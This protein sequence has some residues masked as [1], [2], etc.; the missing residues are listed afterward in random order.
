[1]SSGVVYAS[2]GFVTVNVVGGAFVLVV[3][4]LTG[5]WFMKRSVGGSR[6]ITEPLAGQQ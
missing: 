6:R 3:L 5:W 4:T 1:L 2:M